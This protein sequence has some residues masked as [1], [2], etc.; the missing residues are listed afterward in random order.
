MQAASDASTP[1]AP[2]ALSWRPAHQHVEHVSVGDI[3]RVDAGA[4]AAA[5]V[6][7]G[8][9]RA[10]GGG[11]QA[12]KGGHITVHCIAQQVCQVGLLAAH[13]GTVAV[14]QHRRD[15]QLLLVQGVD[16]AAQRV[17]VLGYRGILGHGVGRVGAAQQARAARR[18]QQAALPVPRRVE[19][20]KVAAGGAVGGGA[21][22]GARRQVE[23]AAAP[24]ASLA[25]AP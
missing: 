2:F 23:R 12:R 4:D 7:A 6:E 20:A 21:E 19:H 5:V 11:Q 3:P 14:Q 13:V 9:G 1:T 25:A 8:D 24:P 22:A 16:G 17:Q 10:R 18:G 15:A